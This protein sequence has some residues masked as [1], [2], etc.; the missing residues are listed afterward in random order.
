MADF[1]SSGLAEHAWNAG[2]CVDWSEMTILDQ[3]EN[4]HIRLTE[5]MPYQKAAP[6]S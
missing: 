4:L 1:N 5:G 2:H 3:H 6:P